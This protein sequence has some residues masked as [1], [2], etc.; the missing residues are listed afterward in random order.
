MSATRLYQ[1]TQCYDMKSQ[2]LFFPLSDNSTSIWGCKN[3]PIA[4]LAS[5]SLKL[6]HIQVWKPKIFPLPAIVR[7]HICYCS[8]VVLLFSIFLLS[9]T[10]LSPLTFP[11]LYFFSPSWSPRLLSSVSVLHLSLFSLYFSLLHF[12]LLSLFTACFSL[13]YLFS[14]DQVLLD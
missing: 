3:P 14:S 9:P 10:C 12:P 11:V 13:I 1:Q 2:N 6:L 8:Q 5:K 4:I 7:L